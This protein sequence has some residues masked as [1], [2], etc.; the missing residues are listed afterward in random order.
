MK[1]KKYKTRDSIF[2]LSE[3]VNTPNPSI[4]RNTQVPNILKMNKYNRVTYVVNLAYKAGF[5]LL[6]HIFIHQLSIF[7]TF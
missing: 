1:E 2:H 5:L 3:N 4:D 6:P 7:S